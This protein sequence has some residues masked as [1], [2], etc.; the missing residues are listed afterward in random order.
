MGEG[1]GQ[2]VQFLRH[3]PTVS[4]SLLAESKI[5][6]LSPPNPVSLFFIW[7]QDQDLV[8]TSIIS[9]VKTMCKCP[10]DVRKK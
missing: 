10:Y 1:R 8:A 3:E 2:R 9:C 7:L 4:P 6:F 5:T